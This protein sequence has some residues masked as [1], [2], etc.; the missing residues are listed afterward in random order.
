MNRE[1]VATV[2]VCVTCLLA[3]S[4]AA[5]TL[6]SSVTTDP[7]EVIDLDSESLPVGT[8]G[9]ESLKSQV[10]SE[11]TDGET[12]TGGDDG[13]QSSAAANGR[14]G[15]GDAAGRAAEPGAGEAERAGSGDGSAEAGG[16][17]D[18]STQSGGSGSGEQQA[19]GGPVES[20][21]DRLLELLQ[22]FLDALVRFVPVALALGV[23][24]LAVRH[25]DRLRAA[26]R[27]R[28]EAWGL[29]DGPGEERARAPRAPAAPTNDVA[30]AWYE[31]VDALGLGDVR[32][33]AP[34]ECAARARAEGVDDAVVEDVT[35]PFE[36]VTYAH[37]PVTESR[38]ERA[39]SALER[40]RSQY[41][42]GRR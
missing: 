19:A 26:V 37:R 21:L 33:R 27:D 36:E 17:N 40:F 15:S 38:K 18:G 20:L 34:R 39:R 23:L 10:Q 32:S 22:A 8:D 30:E 4:T 25:R 41:D 6:D 12:G 5:S 24:A 2:V 7:D 11:G 42:G 31:F 3:V 35:E 16:S 13:E 28:L 29:V 9:A 14:P 1:S